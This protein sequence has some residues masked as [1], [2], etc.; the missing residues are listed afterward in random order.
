MFYNYSSENNN[1]NLELTKFFEKNNL[2]TLP[3]GQDGINYIEVNIYKKVKLIYISG[4]TPS[5]R[6]PLKD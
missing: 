2:L 1:K 6:I 4:L 5:I 3:D